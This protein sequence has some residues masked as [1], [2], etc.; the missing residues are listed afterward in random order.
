MK[1]INIGQPAGL[2]LNDSL[3]NVFL[4]LKYSIIS[5]KIGFTQAYFIIDW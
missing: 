3:N 1:L 5:H 2:N 4:K